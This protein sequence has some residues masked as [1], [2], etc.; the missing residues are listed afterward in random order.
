MDIFN[1]FAVDEK[2]V[3]EGVWWVI[4]S[5]TNYFPVDEAEI[6]GRAAVKV[7]SRES[8]KF[9][10]CVDKKKKPYLLRGAD[11][12]DATAERLNAEALAETVILDWRHWVIAGKDVPYSREQ[13][14]AYFT[15]P[16]WARL[17]NLFFGI[18]YRD[19]VFNVQQDE[20]IVKNS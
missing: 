4:E 10:Q 6:N 18:I 11:I 3:I 9:R 19:D 13:V 7:A 2:K 1:E 20:A 15:E 5:R 17:K 14:A 16:Q 12:D 8:P